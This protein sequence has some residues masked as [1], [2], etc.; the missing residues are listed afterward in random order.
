MLLGFKTI[1]VSAPL[2]VPP[3]TITSSSVRIKPASVAM[4]AISHPTFTPWPKRRKVAEMIPSTWMVA[5]FLLTARPVVPNACA[6]VSIFAPF[7]SIVLRL[8]GRSSWV[9]GSLNP[10]T[11]VTTVRL[12][13]LKSLEAFAP[14]SPEAE[15][16]TMFLMLSS[17]ARCFASFSVCSVFLCPGSLKYTVLQV[18]SV[19]IISSILFFCIRFINVVGFFIVKGAG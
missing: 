3:I 18:M 14:V 13:F 17:W 6:A 9:F 4:Q 15:A 11:C 5:N 19:N 12:W 16:T 7:F 8:F 10:V 2:A 1:A